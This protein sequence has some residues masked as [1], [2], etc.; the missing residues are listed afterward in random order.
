MRSAERE[1]GRDAAEI[2]KERIE[3]I[4]TNFMADKIAASDGKK[5]LGKIRINDRVILPQGKVAC[6]IRLPK[7]FRPT[8]SVPI[9]L[10]FSVD[11][12]A[13]KVI[14]VTVEVEELSQVV[15]ARRPLPRYHIVTREDILVERVDARDLPQSAILSPEE[16]LNK[17]TERM[18]EPGTVLRADLVA[19]P[20]MINRGDRVRIV[21]ETDGMW[22]SAMGEAK[23]RGGRGDQIRVEN[24]DSKKAIFARVIDP[25][26]VQ[27]E[28]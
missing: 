11:G 5:R 26:T 22:V 9:S 20:P 8:G 24:L 17:R 2:S 23:E 1:K 18:I 3:A 25:K 6:D 7:N 12:R 4:V 15:I 13:A 14:W 21:I 19:I 16:V 10:R 28:F 27:V